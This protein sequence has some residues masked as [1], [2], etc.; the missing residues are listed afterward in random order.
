[1]HHQ[2]AVW[3]LHQLSKFTSTELSPL[4]NLGSSTHLFRSIIQPHIADFIFTPLLLRGVDTIH[5]DLKAGDG[6]DISG[7][8][9]NEADFKR[10]LASQPKAVLCSNMLEHVLDPQDLANRCLALVPPGG[11][12]FVTVPYSYPYHRDPI[13]TLYRPN[14]EE[15]GRLFAPHEIL[16]AQIVTAGS[17]L[18][19]LKRRPL[20]IF[21]HILRFPFPFVGYEKW[22]RS[23]KKLHWLFNNYSMTCIVV[24]KTIITD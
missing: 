11:L 10:L 4:L 3:L 7:D 17:Y 22:K 14:P 8:I 16:A 24:R 1:M 21:R 15:L 9:F 13:D 20:K 5:F 23:M 18:D 2:E 6:V 19:E 12:V